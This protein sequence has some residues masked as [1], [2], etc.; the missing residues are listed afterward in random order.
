MP[1]FNTDPNLETHALKTSHYGFSATRLEDLD[2]SE[3]TLVTIVQDDSSSVDSFRTEME[4]TL[5]AI[6]EACRKSPRADNLMIRL[7]TF[8]NGM[9]EV[10]GFKRLSTIQ[11]NDY[12]GILGTGGMTALC[13][14]TE[15]AVRATTAYSKKLIEND[16]SVNGI[17]FVIT[18]GIEKALG[19]ATN[20]E[21]IESLISILI[22]VNLNPA[23][24]RYLQDFEKQ[25][26]FSKYVNIG[27]ASA[28][29]L[30]KLGEFVSK[31]ISSQSQSLGSGGSSQVLTF[32]SMFSI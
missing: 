30:A 3:Y 17:L 9:Q 15:N 13:D 24:D 8:S 14:A 4:K 29:K 25:V 6:V 11:P 19:D 1:K 31:S 7:C 27:D 5:A 2:S 28:S 21:L 10:H 16:F 20:Q 32:S 22:G 26:G 23:A 18:D 12:G